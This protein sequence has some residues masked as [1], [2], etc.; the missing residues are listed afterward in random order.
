MDFVTLAFFIAL[1]SCDNAPGRTNNVK[2]LSVVFAGTTPCS[3]IIRPIHKIKEEP[4][5]PM[6]E[7]NC[8]VVEWKLT[9]YMDADTKAPTRYILKGISRSIVKETNM[10]SEPGIK[11]EAEGSWTIVKGTKTNTDA[12]LYQLNPDKPGMT[13]SF[14][15]LGDNLLHIVDQNEKLMIG[16]EFHSYTLNRVS[17]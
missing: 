5:C 3:N 10:Y 11:S 1:M 6:A 7:C 13:L 8:F 4:D 2:E 17:N 14:L 12:I 9:L 15:K 16:N